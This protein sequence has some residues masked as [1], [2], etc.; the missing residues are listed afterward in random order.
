MVLIWLGPTTTFASFHDPESLFACKR[1]YKSF[2]LEASSS[3]MVLKNSIVKPSGHGAVV[4]FILVMANLISSSL[5]GSSITAH[6]TWVVFFISKL[7]KKITSFLLCRICCLIQCF[8]KPFSLSEFITFPSVIKPG[9]LAISPSGFNRLAK[10]FAGL[11][12]YWT[13]FDL[14]YYICCATCFI[15]NNWSLDIA[16]S[17]HC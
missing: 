9:I 16:W 3:K 14:G 5:V 7:S 4:F 12:P 10:H 8:I 2:N 6:S 17:Y 1:W 13:S 15:S 11:L